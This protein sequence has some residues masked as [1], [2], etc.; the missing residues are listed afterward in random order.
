MS[1]VALQALIK[2][3]SA[4]LGDFIVLLGKEQEALKRA[5][6]AALPEL[7]E[8]KSQLVDQLNALEIS[9]AKALGQTEAT[10]AP[11]AVLGRLTALPGGQALVE[12]W[13]DLL[14]LAR[15]AKQL[16]E[17]NRQLL[18]MHLQQTSELLA[19]LTRKAERQTLY[20]SNGQAQL[21]TGSRIV[22]SA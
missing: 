16:H 12:R 21:N 11:E 10:L 4:L 15:Q 8:A 1:A 3:E 5:D 22:D 7:G 17:Q 6:A 14:E 18:Q 9:R 13:K 19:A 2:Q 20:G